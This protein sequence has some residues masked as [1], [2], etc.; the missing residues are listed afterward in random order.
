[1]LP[2]PQ[3]FYAAILGLGCNIGISKMA[4]VSKGISEDVLTNL[5]N[6]HLSVDNLRLAIQKILEFLEKL[7]L[8][9]IHKDKQL[10]HTSS[11][12]RKIKIA[13]DSLNA[14]SSY[15][16]F[17]KDMGIVNYSFIDNL[18]RM[19]YST[20]I[21][22]SER[23][24]TYVI[25][26]VTY[27]A[28][29]KS[30][31]HSTDTHGYTEVIFAI[32]YLLGIDFAPRIK[33]IKRAI[34]YSFKSRSHYEALGYKVLPG[35]YFNEKI[36]IEQWNNI[37][38]L[39]ATIK[40]GEVNASQIFK[41]LNSYSKQHP[42]YCALKEFGRIIKTTFVLRYFD[43]V[44]L[45]Q[46]IEKQLNKIELSNKF[47]KAISFDNNNEMQYGSKEEQEIVINCQMLIQNA[48]ILWNELYLS[49]KLVS[50]SDLVERAEILTILSNGSI[51]S[52]GHI[53]FSGE[54]DFTGLIDLILSEF[55]LEKILEL[56]L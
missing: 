30:D 39:I 21:S 36:I 49:Q 48:I 15:K 19:L 5:V 24:S 10:L 20:A 14:N 2:S 9:Y 22:S 34:L 3:V 51:Q 8:T 7:G 44:E 25:D 32:M 6:W 38:R 41:R 29:I 40:L 13:V 33:N 17:G 31:M 55:D 35:R 26:G 16:Y 28:S 45:R 1:M 37:L 54:Y 43:D 11:D 47:A 53:N 46:A 52:W 42:L 18:D 27:S 12:G 4:N 23:E 56:Q 50:T